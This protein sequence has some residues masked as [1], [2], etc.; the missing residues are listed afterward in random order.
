MFL[1]TFFYSGHV[2]MYFSL[3]K[4]ITQN[5]ILIY[6]V[7]CYLVLPFIAFKID[8]QE[9][10]ARITYSDIV[11]TKRSYFLLLTFMPNQSRAVFLLL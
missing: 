4:F 8:G 2:L 10:R 9:A 3:I 1:K 6:C 7:V 5:S 11:C